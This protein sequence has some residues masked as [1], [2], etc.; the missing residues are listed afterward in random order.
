MNKKGFTLIELIVV[1]AI[2][3]LLSTLAVV[4]L[5]SARTKARDAKRLSDIK[6]VQSALEIYYSDNAKYPT[7]V[8]SVV[9]GTGGAVCLDN[10]TA[11]WS[12][13]CSNPYMSVVPKDPGSN[14]YSY[15]SA[16]G[17]TYSIAGILEGEMGELSAGPFTA[18]PSAI[19]N[20]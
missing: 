10:S 12:A 8:E 9:L 14:G 6:Q 1:I 2:I 15:V 4:A 16:N 3:G 5:G 18:T 13:T 17:T 20:N 11:G 19:T 7:A